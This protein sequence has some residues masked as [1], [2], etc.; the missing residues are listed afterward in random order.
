M[1]GAKALVDA[2]LE[3]EKGGGEASVLAIPPCLAVV[4]LQNG[5]CCGVGVEQSGEAGERK[6]RRGRPPFLG[7]PLAG[8]ATGGM[9][10]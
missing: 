2:F 3:W 4:H 7:S 10:C 8:S 5:A 6:Q 9:A 1:G